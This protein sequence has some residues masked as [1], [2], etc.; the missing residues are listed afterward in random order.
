MTSKRK[1]KTIKT[2]DSKEVEQNTFFDLSEIL[3]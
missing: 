3:R 1:P 2:I